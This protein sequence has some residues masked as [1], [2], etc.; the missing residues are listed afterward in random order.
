MRLR[1]HILFWVAYVLFKTYLNLSPETMTL[2]RNNL[3]LVSSQLIYLIAKIPLVY[4][5]FFIIDNY[6]QGKW[7]QWQAI[8]LITVAFCIAIVGMTL[9]NHKIILP[10]ILG[11]ASSTSPFNSESLVY[12]LFTLIFVAG[13]AISI[14]FV[15][16]QYKSSIR[17]I[18]LQKEKSET[19]LKYLKSQINPHFLFNTLNNIYSLARKGSEQTAE[20]ILKLSKLMRFMLYEANHSHILLTDELK[21][22]QDY[23]ALERLRYTDRLTITYNESIDNLQQRI[24][25]LIL[26]H[27]VENAFKHGAS[28]SRFESYISIDI[29]LKEAVL[30]ATIKNSKTKELHEE[31]KKPIG[32]E[33]IKRQ[34]ELV[35]PKHQLDVQDHAD[36]FIVN[37]TL[38]LSK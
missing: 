14:R 20:S 2:W 15:R 13:A 1:N 27:F 16:K 37:L 21:L 22:I 24:A 30:I 29:K 19:E 36:H 33:N 18:E 38:S 34:L 26:I 3:L 28:E 10:H 8:I 17:E 31:G 35:Y 12:H 6:L 5:C 25:P 23:I 11:I 9:L 32:L 7:K 4:T